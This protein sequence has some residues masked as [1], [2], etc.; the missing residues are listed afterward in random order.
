MLGR[1]GTSL[2]SSQGEGTC[3]EEESEEFMGTVNIQFGELMPNSLPK[4]SV[5]QLL[6]IFSNLG[7]VI[8]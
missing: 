6:S 8:L 7:I 1:Q 3:G 5:V 4:Q 2:W